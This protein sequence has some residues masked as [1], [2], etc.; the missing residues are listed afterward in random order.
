[1]PQTV[2]PQIICSRWKVWLERNKKRV[3]LRNRGSLGASSPDFSGTRKPLLSLIIL[4]SN[5]RFESSMTSSG[6]SSLLLLILTRYSLCRI[7]VPVPNWTIWHLLCI[8]VLVWHYF[9]IFSLSYLLFF[10]ILKIII[11]FIDLEITIL[12]VC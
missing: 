2:Y 11:R 12:R 3:S 10:S 4:S 1:M 6:C 5:I 8:C 7:S 9:S